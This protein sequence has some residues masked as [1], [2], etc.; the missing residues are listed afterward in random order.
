M[1]ISFVTFS[2][3]NEMCPC[4]RDLLSF[5]SLTNP[6][7][8][9]LVSA[10]RRQHR[11]LYLFKIVYGL[12]P[13]YLTQLHPVPQQ[14][15]ALPISRQYWIPPIRSKYQRHQSY[16][17]PSALQLATGTIYSLLLGVFIHRLFSRGKI[18]TTPK[19][20]I[21]TLNHSG[22]SASFTPNFVIN[23]VP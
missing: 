9:K 11:L 20:P 13:E 22:C 10:F 5:F 6:F 12:A 1:L 3:S 15:Y 2:L 21:S 14:V 19:K 23:V 16:F 17:L 7:A 18:D 8:E 4:V